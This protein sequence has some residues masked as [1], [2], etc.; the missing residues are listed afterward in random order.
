MVFTTAGGSPPRTSASH[1][2]TTRGDSTSL[3]AGTRGCPLSE[4][5]DPSSEEFA[6]EG[7]SQGASILIGPV[8]RYQEDLLL[9][10][11]K[12]ALCE[13]CARRLIGGNAYLRRPRGQ[14]CAS[15]LHMAPQ[16][17]VEASVDT[18]TSL[19]TCAR[20]TP[21]RRKARS[22]HGLKVWQ[23][24]GVTETRYVPCRHANAEAVSYEAIRAAW[25]RLRK[26]Y[27]PG[28]SE[29]VSVE[30]PSCIGKTPGISASTEHAL[31]RDMLWGWPSPTPCWSKRSFA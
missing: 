20:G 18:T 30:P 4:K 5:G 16:P 11:P 1:P 21:A 10:L 31:L 29:S 23:Q 24:D 8:R 2:G 22:D 27:A 26:P 6:K 19:D 7:L 9:I 3:D 13:N 12:L 15:T 28:A 14:L 17:M 25:Q